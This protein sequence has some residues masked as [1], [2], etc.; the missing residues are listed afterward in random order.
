MHTKISALVSECEETSGRLFEAEVLEVIHNDILNPWLL[1]LRGSVLVQTFLPSSCGYPLEPGAE[2]ILYLS[3]PPNFSPTEFGA[4]NAG[5][6][7]RTCSA[8][9]LLFTY[10]CSE[11]V[12]NPDEDALKA[13]R[14]LCATSS[15]LL[16]YLP[17]SKV[18]C[19]LPFS[20]WTSCILVITVFWLEGI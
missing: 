4:D 14:A 8:D 9:A 15:T 12:R 11:N 6:E 13:S 20:I 5:D 2:Y 17:V 1:E 19:D 16:P 10:F 18:L 3:G 7:N